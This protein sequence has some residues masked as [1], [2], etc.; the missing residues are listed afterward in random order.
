MFLFVGISLDSSLNLSCKTSVLLIPF[1]CPVFQNATQTAWLSLE[2]ARCT[3]G[4]LGTGFGNCL[5]KRKTPLFNSGVRFLTNYLFFA[6]LLLL[7]LLVAYV[8]GINDGAKHC[9]EEAQQKIQLNGFD[10][11]KIQRPIGDKGVQGAQNELIQEI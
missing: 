9:G 1:I 5:Y 6:Y 11:D 2:F 4:V 7:D 3:G 8:V 10:L